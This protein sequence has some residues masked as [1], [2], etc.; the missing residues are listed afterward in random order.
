MPKDKEAKH[1]KKANQKLKPY[2]VMQ[3]LLKNSDENHLVT[4]PE[5][6]SYLENDCGIE[7]ERRSVYKDIAEIN[8]AMLIVEN[9]IDIFEAEEWL[10]ED[11]D[12][13]EKFIVYDSHRK[14]FYVSRRMYDLYDI[15]LMAE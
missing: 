1:G 7:A 13:E 5:I 10:E 3:Y 14:G 2:L 8:K 15:R 9:G 4:A 6:V 12:N 11:T